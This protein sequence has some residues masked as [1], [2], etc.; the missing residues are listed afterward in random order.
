MDKFIE[1]INTLDKGYNIYSYR[2][3]IIHTGL[4]IIRT[5]YNKYVITIIINRDQKIIFSFE[6]GL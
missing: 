6:D 1:W 5:N 2:V 4:L 3:V